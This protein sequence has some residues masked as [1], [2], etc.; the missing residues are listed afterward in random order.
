[1]LVVSASSISIFSMDSVFA[2]HGTTQLDVSNSAQFFPDPPAYGGVAAMFVNVDLP[3]DSDA[4]ENTIL[5]VEGAPGLIFSS[6]FSSGICSEL[7]PP[8]ATGAVVT[9]D[10]GQTSHESPG[11]AVIVFE[12]GATGTDTSTFITVQTTNLGAA[13]TYLDPRTSTF[14]CSDCPNPI[15]ITSPIDGLVTTNTTPTIFGTAQPLH[16]IELSIDGVVVGTTTSDATGSWIF[17]TPSTLTDGQHTI[18]V[19]DIDATSA[20]GTSTP[21]ADSVTITVDTTTN[22][23]FDPT[24]NGSTTNDNTPTLFGT[25]EIGSTVEVFIDGI[26]VGTTTVDALGDWS[27][28]PASALSEGPRIVTATATDTLGNTVSALPVTITIDTSITITIDSHT[29]G[30]VTND[31]TPTLFG[32]AENDSTVEVFID[33][34]SIGTTPSLAGTW[35]IVSPILSEGP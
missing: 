6:A 35:S 34:I 16:D 29:N 5:T 11:S 31:N 19:T 22:V 32:T 7:T 14:T 2:D 3:V 24:L 9:C 4:A 33:G 1:M 8:P 30:D 21:V 15:S 26:S 25:A 23:S 20:S 17:V 27:L 18:V 10:M 13:V 28:T 12:F